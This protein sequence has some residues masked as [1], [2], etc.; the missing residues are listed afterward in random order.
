MSGD[1][2]AH[3]LANHILCIKLCDKAFEA[4]AHAIVVLSDHVTDMV[5]Y[6][7]QEAAKR[8]DIGVTTLKKVCRAELKILRWPFRKLRSQQKENAKYAQRGM[9]SIT[10]I[11]H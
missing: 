9:S 3:L 1:K 11:K 2:H 4:G 8:L 5:V 6:S 10:R 7:L